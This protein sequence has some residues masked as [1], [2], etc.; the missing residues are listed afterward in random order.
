MK[1]NTIT[2]LGTDTCFTYVLRRLGILH[3]YKPPALE[4]SEYAAIRDFITNHEYSGRRPWVEDEDLEPGEILFWASKKPVLIPRT[5]TEDGH[6][7]TLNRAVDFHFAIVENNPEYYSDTTR[8]L[9]PCT[10]TLQM[11]KV[12]DWWCNKKPDYV[13]TFRL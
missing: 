12:G 5:I 2:L 10:P 11:K 6:I 1:L 8:M 7:L 13:F 9:V 4:E 3:Q